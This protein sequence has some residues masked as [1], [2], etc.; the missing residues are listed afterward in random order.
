LAVGGGKSARARV[1]RL[2]PLTRTGW[3]M[4]LGERAAVEGLLSI[5]QP[6]LSLELG[7][8]EGG[9]LERI[10]AHSDEV[11]TFDFDPRVA[12][13]PR[14]A[15]FHRGDY[16]VLLPQLLERLAQEGRNVDFV[17]V[18][19]DHSAAGVRRDL[20]HL[21]SSPAVSRT[22][23]LVHDSMNEDVRAGISS[24]RYEDYDK[25]AYVDLDF[26][27]MA[28]AD[29]SPLKDAWGGLALIVVDAED[30][31]AFERFRHFRVGVD[32]NA[33]IRRT[34]SP[35]VSRSRGARAARRAR[36]LAR[37]AAGAA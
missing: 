13:P 32:E 33:V 1:D 31:G 37:A 2:L 15:V 8:A 25:V 10:A 6:P 19:G 18:D 23:V 7:T 14:N 24:V 11:H 3:W 26:V 12:D 4:A 29:P 17:L 20:E 21:L 36:S 35:W 16:N 9:S 22:I 5:L 34:P 27:A 30:P 28:Q